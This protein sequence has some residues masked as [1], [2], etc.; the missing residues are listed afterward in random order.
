[1]ITGQITEAEFVAAHQLH[2]RKIAFVLS[3]VTLIAASIGVV[4]FFTASKKLGLILF[5]GGIGGLIGELIQSRIFLPL[6]LRKLYGQVKG[7][8]DLTYSWSSDAL[9]VRSDHG[10]AERP[11]ADFIKARENGKVF[12]LYFNDA[13]FE[14]VSKQW[15]HTPEQIDDFR[16]NLDVVK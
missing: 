10:N 15:F 5:M 12:L 6:R 1:M 9:S 11:W 2:R 7:R 14:I 13:R 16:K 8:T 3:V 4:L